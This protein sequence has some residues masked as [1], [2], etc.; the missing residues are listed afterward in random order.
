[1]PRFWQRELPQN[2]KQVSQC[3]WDELNAILLEHCQQ[4]E[5]R[6]TGDRSLSVGRGTMSGTGIPAAAG[7]GSFELASTHSPKVN[8]TVYFERAF[9]RARGPRAKARGRRVPFMG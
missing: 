9:E 5:R 1:M 3:C 2:A 7:R 4:D 6:I 8:G